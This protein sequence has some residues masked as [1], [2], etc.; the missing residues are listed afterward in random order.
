VRPYGRWPAPPGRG[1][2]AG[3]CRRLVAGPIQL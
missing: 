3:W 2:P 1:A